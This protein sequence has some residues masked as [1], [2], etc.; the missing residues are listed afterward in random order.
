MIRKQELVTQTTKVSFSVV[1]D[2]NTKTLNLDKLPQIGYNIVVDSDG[3]LMADIV[4]VNQD[5]F[6]KAPL[7]LKRISVLSG[8]IEQPT[9]T[10]DFFKFVILDSEDYLTRVKQYQVVYVIWRQLEYYVT[11][12]TDYDPF[13]P[14]YNLE[15]I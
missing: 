2:G 14:N 7:K 12:P 3:E 8:W 9:L 1:Y 6:R 13:G 4:L 10:N 5:Q 15:L 11:I